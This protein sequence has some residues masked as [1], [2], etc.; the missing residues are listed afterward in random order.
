MAAGVRQVPDW[1]DSAAYAPLLGAD[2][3]LFAWEWLRRDPGYRAAFEGAVPGGAKCGAD[4]RA[5]RWGLHAFL[6]PEP[7]VPDARPMWTAAV[8]PFVLR[9]E[10]TPP[11]GC[12]AFDLGRLARVSTLITG[13]KGDEHLLLSDGFRT[14]RL[15][16]VC[17][18]LRQGPADL[19]FRVE[20]LACAE[21]AVLALR[22]F[23][24]VWQTGA[25]SR[26]LHRRETRA[27]RWTLLLRAGDALTVGATQR[28]IAAVLLS[29]DARGPRW[30]VESAS[31]RSRVQRLVRS[32]NA[33]QAGA[34]LALLGGPRS[35]LRKITQCAP[36]RQAPTKGFD[37]RA[38][39]A[40]RR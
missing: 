19:C 24:A 1:R 3:S 28:E 37:G 22:R 35:V 10:A 26:S 12:E 2:R 14:I 21:R 33:M 20:G 18:S 4:E 8:D 25:F 32:A 40:E 17:G 27:A 29:R 9:I 39:H 5:A 6:P 38:D 23:L 13:G 16:V 15:D 34:G 11:T 30:R 31:L 7:T 36:G